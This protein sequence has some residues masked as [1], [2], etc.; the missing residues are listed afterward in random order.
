MIVLKGTDA[1]DIQGLVATIGFFDGVHLGHRFLIE[2][3]RQ[4]AKSRRLP[5][6]VITFPIHPRMVLQP[7]FHPNL[8]NT[9]EEKLAQ[10]ETTGVDYCIVLDFSLELSRLSAKEF[11]TEVLHKKYYVKT[12][13][14]G[15][16][17]RFGHDRAD[18]FEQ[19]IAYGAA[20]GIELVKASPFD[21]GE[22]TVSSSGIRDRLLNGHV[23]EAA[24]L[25]SYPY[26]LTGSIVDGYKVGRKLGFPTANIAVES[27]DKIVPAIGVYA[28]WVDVEG[29]R[30][31]GMLYI[32]DR[33]TLENGTDITLEVNILNFDRNIYNS[34]ITVTFIAYVR[35]DIKFNSLE[36]LKEQLAV[37]RDTVD[38]ILN[39]DK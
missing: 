35:G 22:V 19:Y 30:H 6:A 28:V 21:A 11:I 15:Y 37:D 13:V 23:E 24:K 12:L 9:T 26:S 39:N 32:G 29:V 5:S 4:T 10:L 27:P 17:H 31:K 8:L 38:R 7:G 34:R 16:D 36:E 2:E 14:I 25:L 20:C 18:G 3:L 1:L 33:P